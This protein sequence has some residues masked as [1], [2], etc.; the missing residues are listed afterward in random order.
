[1]APPTVEG[2]AMTIGADE[3]DFSGIETTTEESIPN[4]HFFEFED[5]TSTSSTINTRPGDHFQDVDDSSEDRVMGDNQPHQTPFSTP[6]NYHAY[7]WVDYY[8]F[9]KQAWVPSKWWDA[10]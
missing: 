1:M 6:E 4:D 8:N 7:S 3:F 5:V 10:N 9:Q 2:E